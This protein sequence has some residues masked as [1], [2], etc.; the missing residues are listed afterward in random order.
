[1]SKLELRK[2]FRE[3]RS[4]I[5]LSY[6]SQAADAAAELFSQHLMFKQSDAIACYLHFKNEFDSQPIIDAIWQANKRCYLP[7]LTEE[8]TL[9]FFPYHE[10]DELHVN[11]YSIFEPVNKTQEIA[12]SD[13]Q[14]VLMPLLAF[15]LQGHRLGAG[16]GYYDRSFA[17]V[18]ETLFK[19]P[20]LIGLGYAAQQAESLPC[21]DWD[22][23]LDGI[24]T[25]RHCLFFV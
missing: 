25:E 3:L 21:D 13:L 14:L 1:M 17:F 11:R 5:P 2:H 6:R 12:A 24:V 18:R 19:K 10:G 16:G 15:D 8:N 23:N 22:V 4:Q 20:R 9:R 7:V